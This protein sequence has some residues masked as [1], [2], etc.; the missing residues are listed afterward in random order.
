[1]TRPKEYAVYKGDEFLCWGTAK[2][3]AKRLGVTP[4]TIHFYNTPSYRRR[5]ESRNSKN[6]IIVVPLDE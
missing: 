4:N 2:E 1:M 6:P 3:C 5:L